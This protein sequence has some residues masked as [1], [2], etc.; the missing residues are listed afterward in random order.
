MSVLTKI[1]LDY[2]DVIVNVDSNGII[3]FDIDGY[4]IVMSASVLRY[5]LNCYKDSGFDIPVS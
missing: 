4:E 3:T 5:T 2:D 1:T